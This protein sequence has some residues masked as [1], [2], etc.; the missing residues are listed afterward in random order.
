[1]YTDPKNNYLST[2]ASCAP[3]VHL[4][5]YLNTPTNAQSSDRCSSCGQP[6]ARCVVALVIVEHTAHKHRGIGPAS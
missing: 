2:L 4:L 5:V 6:S 3:R 1:M